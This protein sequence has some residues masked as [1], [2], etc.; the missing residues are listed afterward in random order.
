MTKTNKFKK[1]FAVL[2]ACA[3]ALIGAIVA[4][5]RPQTL[6]TQAEAVE[7]T[8]YRLRIP[9]PFPALDI[10][11]GMFLFPV[12]PL[13]LELSFGAQGY[14][15]LAGSVGGAYVDLTN[16]ETAPTSS[17]FSIPVMAATSTK[18]IV[19]FSLKCYVSGSDNFKA[20][21]QLTQVTIRPMRD[22]LGT[23]AYLGPE[24]ELRFEEL[25]MLIFL[26][27]SQ[28][29]AYN[30]VDPES[31]N[32]PAESLVFTY[33]MPGAS[34]NE[35]YNSGYGE[36]YQSG[37]TDGYNTGKTDGKAEGITQGKTEGYNTGYAEGVAAAGNYTFFSLISAVIDAPIKA[38]SGLLNFEVLGVNM[39]GL[40]LSL[41][42]VAFVFGVVKLFSGNA[43]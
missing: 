39:K 4:V 22:Y 33:D 6:K 42:T 41:L 8:V 31:L 16:V 12:A 23:G 36:G 40:L 13:V 28:P 14:V 25:N 19:N 15:K 29:H 7:T 1:F 18:P 11:F 3:I 38:F 35:G 20:S 21:T 27:A 26:R 34:F 43:S 32:Y 10:S 9:C 2:F 24:I 37:K 5:P 17:N 30:W